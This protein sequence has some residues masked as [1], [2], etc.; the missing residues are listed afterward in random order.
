MFSKAPHILKPVVTSCAVPQLNNLERA[1]AAAHTFLKKN[2][3]DPY[4]TKNM[5]YYKTLL[6]VEEYL[7]DHEEQPYEVRTL[8]PRRPSPASRLNQPVSLSPRAFS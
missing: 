4:L 8:N 7:I 6:D 2:P 5:N 1:V 3:N